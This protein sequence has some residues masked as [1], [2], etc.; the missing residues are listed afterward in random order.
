ML[1]TLLS[2]SI[3]TSIYF[4]IHAH[5]HACVYFFMLLLLHVFAIAIRI[6]F[7]ALLYIVITIASLFGFFGLFAIYASTVL[8]NSAITISPIST[9]PTI[10]L[11]L[12]LPDSSTPCFSVITLISNCQVISL[13]I[14]NL[15]IIWTSL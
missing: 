3:S 2:I 7:F 14:L 11:S 5:A 15:I 6:V 10:Y 8:S 13:F 4:I 1:I 12:S 9:T